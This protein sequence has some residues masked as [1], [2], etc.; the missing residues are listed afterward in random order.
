MAEIPPHITEPFLRLAIERGYMKAADAEKMIS[1]P[2]TSSDLDDLDLALRCLREKLLTSEQVVELRRSCGSSPVRRFADFDIDEPIGRGGSGIVYSA[3]RAGTGMRVALKIL[4]RWLSADDAAV[5]RFLREAKILGK[6]NHPNIVKAIDAGMAEERHYL[7]MEYL[8]GGSLRDLVK[9]GGP[10]PETTAFQIVRSVAEALRET[11]THGIVHRDVKPRNI[12]FTF[13]GI[14]KLADLGLARKIDRTHV[15]GAK[16]IIGTPNYISPEQAAGRNNID[17]RS[18]IYS[19]GATLFYA[20]TGHPPFR[21]KDARTLMAAHRAQSPPDARNLNA[22]I[23]EKCSTLISW[24]LE[25]DPSRRPQTPDEVIARINGILTPTR[26]LTEKFERVLF[27]LSMLILLIII[28]LGVLV[29]SKRS[30]SSAEALHTIRGQT[31]KSAPEPGENRET[32]NT[33]SRSGILETG[34][35]ELIEP[36]E[37]ASS[38]PNARAVKPAGKKINPA[39]TIRNKPLPREKAALKTDEPTPKA[40]ETPPEQDSR[41]PRKTGDKALAES[42]N[43][44]DDDLAPYYALVEVITPHLLEREYESAIQRLNQALKSGNLDDNVRE[45]ILWEK[46]ILQDVLNMF[47]ELCEAMQELVGSQIEFDFR[48]GIQAKGNLTGIDV[49]G[50]TFQIDN[51]GFFKIR[52]LSADFIL[53]RLDIM[54][55]N[56]DERRLR[57]SLFIADGAY[58]EAEREIVLAATEGADVTR[59]ARRLKRAKARKSRIETEQRAAKERLDEETVRSLFTK[60]EAAYDNQAWSEA[61][62]YYRSIIREHGDNKVTRNNREIIQD[63]FVRSAHELLRNK[64]VINAALTQNSSDVPG[65][66]TYMYS[67]EENSAKEEMKDFEYNESRWRARRGVLEHCGTQLWRSSIK[68]RPRFSRVEEIRLTYRA[69]YPRI[70]G[71]SFCG[72]SIVFLFLQ[73]QVAVYSGELSEYRKKIDPDLLDA[74]PARD[75]IEPARTHEIR[76]IRK[77][78][79]FRILLNQSFFEDVLIPQ[80]EKTDII[81]IRDTQRCRIAELAITGKIDAKWEEEERTRRE[82]KIAQEAEF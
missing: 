55:K 80:G 12:L 20:V 29:L 9:A 65:A 47:N 3:R 23:S 53:R 72:I 28:G 6:L 82:D 4:P 2:S 38:Q 21:G 31:G 1:A 19:L 64:G 46:R 73:N 39:R 24:M 51:G 40:D 43:A 45:Q 44:V 70:F 59:L 16:R 25:K 14:P 37:N 54:G 60:A 34:P 33:N 30:T 8:D 18:D 63:H 49:A 5:D 52:S 68:T 66:V 26:L 77:G 61:V 17:I 13:D 35:S 79:R 42:G 67:F 74:I 36:E 69:D 41:S 56:T 48:K 62:G 15:Q 27:P 50:A 7:A 75:K 57:A 58:T 81:E 76:I 22:D 32:E 11:S 78:V 71:I 10:L